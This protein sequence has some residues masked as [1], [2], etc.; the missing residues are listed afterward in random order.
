MCQQRVSKAA[1]VRGN[2]A[3]KKGGERAFARFDRAAI[4][5]ALAREED[6][7]FRT[8]LARRRARRRAPR[9]PAAPCRETYARASSRSRPRKEHGAPRLRAPSGCSFS[10]DPRRA[11]DRRVRFPSK[12]SNRS[13]FAPDAR[14]CVRGREAVAGGRTDA[15][16]MLARR[17]TRDFF[18]LP[19]SPHPAV[20]IDFFSWFMNPA[21]GRLLRDT[22]RRCPNVVKSASRFRRE[23]AFSRHRRPRR[24]ARGFQRLSRLSR[25]FTRA[26]FVRHADTPVGEKTDARP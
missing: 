26:I 20:A 5:R 8:H 24:R 9:A 3:E 15:D 16:P 17:N 19:D 11:I 10:G 4:A 21:H 18:R 12:R 25:R 13:G 6:A 7:R 14:G 2:N 22:E 1:S 23:G